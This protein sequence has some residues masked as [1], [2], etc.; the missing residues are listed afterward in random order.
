MC[1]G[2]RLG[3]DVVVVVV[4]VGSSRRRCRLRRSRHPIHHLLRR[5]V[6]AVVRMWMSVHLQLI[7]YI[8]VCMPTTE[9]SLSMIGH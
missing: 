8:S 5:R 1:L 6:D 2:C 3:G 9:Q 7:V 4:V